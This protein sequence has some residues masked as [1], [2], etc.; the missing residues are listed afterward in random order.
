MISTEF[1]KI[2]VR[3]NPPNFR[4]WQVQRNFRTR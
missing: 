2:G 1:Y 4:L 3:P